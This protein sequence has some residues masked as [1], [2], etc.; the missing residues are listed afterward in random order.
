MTLSPVL[1]LLLF[2][3]LKAKPDNFLVR[4]LKNLFLF[5]LGLVLRFRWVALAAFLAIVTYTGAVA[6]T[7]GREFMPELE[8]GNLL[9][10]G[11]FPVNV[12]LEEVAQAIPATAREYSASSPRS[13]SSCPPSAGP[14]TA[15]TRPATTTAKHSSRC[16]PMNS[17][18]AFP[19]TAGRA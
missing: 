2:K 3:N 8:E 15:P 18:P 16:G 9:I 11:T 7:M 1:C 6:A 19:G 14:T 12:S 10:R 4:G 5:Q 17:G 13:P